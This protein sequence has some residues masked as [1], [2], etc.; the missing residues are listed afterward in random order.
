MRVYPPSIRAG[1]MM[2]ALKT[3]S[4]PFTA[5][6]STLKGSRISQMTG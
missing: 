1:S 5:M 2:I 4:T 3:E 6:P